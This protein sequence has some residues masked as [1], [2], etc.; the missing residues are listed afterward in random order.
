MRDDRLTLEWKFSGIHKEALA[1][2]EFKGRTIVFSSVFDSLADR[3]IMDEMTKPPKRIEE[4]LKNLAKDIAAE[5]KA[6]QDS[7]M[8]NYVVVSESIAAAQ[9]KARCCKAR[10]PSGAPPALTW[11]PPV[12]TAGATIADIGDDGARDDD[13][14]DDNEL[15]EAVRTT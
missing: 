3:T 13:G 1:K 14:D 7:L 11:A 5:M 9:S 4:A 15:A 2:A 6:V 12:T 10:M 8:N